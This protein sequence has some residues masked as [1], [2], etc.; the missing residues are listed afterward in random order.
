IDGI[1]T[2]N[3]VTNLEWCTGSKNMKHA[4]VSGLQPLTELMKKSAISACRISSLVRR[5]LSNDQLNEAKTRIKN[6]ELQKTIATSMG[7]S[8]SL[9]SQAVRGITYKEI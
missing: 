1:K 9:L 4:W 3:S 2:N 6:G 8:K 5:R 7:V